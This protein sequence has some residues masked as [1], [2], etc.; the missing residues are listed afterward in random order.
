M[1]M[2]GNGNNGAPVQDEDDLVL[3]G[4]GATCGRHESALLRHPCR[5]SGGGIDI[6]Q[7]LLESQLSRPRAISASWP[8]AGIGARSSARRWPRPRC[9]RSTEPGGDELPRAHRSQSASYPPCAPGWSGPTPGRRGESC[10]DWSWRL[11]SCPEDKAPRVQTARARTELDSHGLPGRIVGD[12][13]YSPTTMASRARKHAK[14]LEATARSAGARPD[15]EAADELLRRAA[16][17][18]PC[19]RR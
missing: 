19:R 18:A 10:G 13:E 14:V 4:Y 3:G 11:A 5:Q 12:G 9:R 15:R 17:A 6:V 16:A 8:A 1:G 7:E 2:L